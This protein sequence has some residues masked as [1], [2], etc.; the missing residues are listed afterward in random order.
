[1]ELVQLANRTL[2]A[3]PCR[4]ICCVKHFP[5]CQL[6]RGGEPLTLIL[7]RPPI[8][9]AFSR[10][11]DIALHH[12]FLAKKEA[13]WLGTPSACFCW[14]HRSCFP[15]DAPAS[16]GGP[17]APPNPRRHRGIY[18]TGSKRR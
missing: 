8:R 2:S 12:P 18:R 5:V 9:L 6:A 13:P 1:M 7:R 11:N 16:P 17:T 14:Q 3:T 4:L 10:G 15:L